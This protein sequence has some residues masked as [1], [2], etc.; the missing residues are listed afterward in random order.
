LNYVHSKW[1]NW[2][3]ARVNKPSGTKERER[4]RER[5]RGEREKRKKEP[6][7]EEVIGIYCTFP[8]PAAAVS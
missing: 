8:S 5:E 4:E 7:V 3:P 6:S 2:P 1:D